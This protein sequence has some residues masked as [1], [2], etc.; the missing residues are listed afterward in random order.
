MLKFLPCYISTGACL[1]L[2]QN[3]LQSY[4]DILKFQQ[5]FINGKEIQWVA[6]S[7]ANGIAIDHI[8][9]SLIP[10]LL[11]SKMMVSS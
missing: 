10:N 4:E 7:N 1:S 3:P 6:L 11:Y 2:H 9:V 5:N 8:I